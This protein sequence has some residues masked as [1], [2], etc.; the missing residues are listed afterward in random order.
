MVDK[1]IINGKKCQYCNNSTVYTDNKVIYG[2]SYGNG[3]IY[4]CKPCDAYV[5]THKGTNKSFGSVA[6]RELRALRS[7]AHRVF[8]PIWKSK[9]LTRVEAYKKL[10][11]FTGIEKAYCH[12]A[13]FNESICNKIID[14]FNK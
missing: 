11:E 13:M 5:G 10:S 3:K 7:K 6:N 2:K 8:D 4:Y 9:Q 12:I 14:G 1:D